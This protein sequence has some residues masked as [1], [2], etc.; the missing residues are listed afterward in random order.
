MAAELYHVLKAIQMLS[1]A[2]E[3]FVHL[4]HIPVIH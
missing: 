3:E 1:S 4:N 2:K